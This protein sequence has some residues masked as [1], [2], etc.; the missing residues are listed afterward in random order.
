VV[1]H[2]GREAGAIRSRRRAAGCCNGL[3]GSPVTEASTS[4]E[5]LLEKTSPRDR[6]SGQHARI[7]GTLQ[8]ARTQT[9]RTSRK[10]AR[11]RSSGR[12]NYLAGRELDRGKAATTRARS[13]RDANA[14]HKA[15]KAALSEEDALA[16]TSTVELAIKLATTSTGGSILGPPVPPP[17]QLP[18]IQRFPPPREQAYFQDCPT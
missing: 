9:K 4:S 18:I 17:R 11:Q 1:L 14:G 10:P 13:R 6:V 3:L 12:R 15:R 5:H 16:K 7:S 2:H 8:V